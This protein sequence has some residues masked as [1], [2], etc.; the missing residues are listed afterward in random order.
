MD[1]AMED[2]QQSALAV[3][4]TYLSQNPMIPLS[5]KNQMLY[6]HQMLPHQLPF[7]IAASNP[8][9]AVASVNEK[10]LNQIASKSRKQGQW[11]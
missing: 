8:S 6:R 4:Q 11:W 2:A 3:Y 10:K 7:Q 5:V 9:A 1:Q